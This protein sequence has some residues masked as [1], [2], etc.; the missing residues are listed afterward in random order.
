MPASGPRGGAN[1]GWR[2][3]LAGM[4]CEIQIQTILDHA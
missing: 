2:V 1:R 3:R 4:R